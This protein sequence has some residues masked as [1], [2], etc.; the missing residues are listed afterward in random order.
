MRARTI[1][2]VGIA[3][4]LVFAVATIPARFVT[5]RMAVP[6]TLEFS[7]AQG[8]LWNGSARANLGAALPIETL[9]WRLLP[10]RL[11]SGRLAFA[12]DATGRAIEAH[13]QLE[14]GLGDLEARDLRAR[15]DAAALAPVVPLAAAW[16]PEGAL[17]ATAP[18]VAW[19][20]RGLRGSAQV[21]WR[22]AALA[23]SDVR[24]LGSYRID[25][26]AEGGPAKITLATLDGPLR[27]AGTG[28]FVPPASLAFS[29]EARAQGASASALEPLLNLLG[30]RRAD[31]ARA[32]EWHSG[33]AAVPSRP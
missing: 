10:A 26:R 7:E 17:T 15:A 28:S 25:A 6:G 19:D 9:R 22:D 1:A 2:V 29:G 5:Q 8:T 32:L 24:P 21:E 13:G 3:A 20:G 31:G 30:P 18:V 11:V 27:L 12:V 16:R 23:A 4:Y 14:R 33:P